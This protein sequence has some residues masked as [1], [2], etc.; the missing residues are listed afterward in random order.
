[1]F[2]RHHQPLLSPA[3]FRQRLVN[4]GLVVL[5]LIATSLAIGTLGYHSF[6]D[7][8]W[9]D[10]FLNSSMILT[11]MGPVDHMDTAPAKLFAAVFALFSGVV[12]PASLAIM[13]APLL[14]R[15]LHHF[16]IASEDRD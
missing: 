13:G 10:A 1:M 11:G 4:S 16:H 2:E 14:H 9:L 6:A 12:F 3:Q 8:T 7:L 15:L 5:A